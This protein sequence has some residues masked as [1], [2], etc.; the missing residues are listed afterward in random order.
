MSSS[1]LKNIRNY[2]ELEIQHLKENVGLKFLEKEALKA[3][4]T[5]GFLHKLLNRRLPDINIIAEIKKASPSKGIICQDF[6]PK[7]IAKSY[8]KAGAAC[9]SVLTDFPSFHGKSDDLRAARHNTTIPILRKDFIFDE[10]QVIESRAMGADCILLIMAALSDLEA[11]RIEEEAFNWDMDVIIEIHNQ[12]ELD[13]ALGLKS[14]LIGINNRNLNTFKTDLSTTKVLRQFI[15]NDYHIISESGLSKSSDI[16]EIKEHGINSFLI[17]ENFMKSEN[18]EL[19][20]RN[21]FI[22]NENNA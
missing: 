3:K 13:R 7:Q 21:L 14:K 6:H 17:G 8:Q 4:D 19:E 11:K 20:F 16:F 2:K 18:I 22:E 12:K 1:I 15:P 10:C 5:R 9:I